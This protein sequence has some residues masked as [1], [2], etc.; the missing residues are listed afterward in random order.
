MTRN[1]DNVL[2]GGLDLTRELVDLWSELPGVMFA[3]KDAAGR[4][5][6]VNQA[7]VRRS[8]A[9]SRAQVIGRTAAELFLPALA[10]RYEAQDAEVM[11][12]GRPLRGELEVIRAEG[13]EP[14]WYLTTKLPLFRQDDAAPPA[15]SSVLAG[16]SGSSGA[17][18]DV[19]AVQGMGPGDRARLASGSGARSSGG[20]GPAAG[21]GRIAAGLVTI[22]T[23]LP[24]LGSSGQIGAAL[25]RVVAAVRAGL[26][27]QPPQLP[28][29]AS[30]AAAAGTSVSA[31]ERNMRKVF[32]LSPRAYV[33]QQRINRAMYLLAETD[34][35]ISEVATATGFYDQ[36]SL[37]RQLVR[38]VGETPGGFRH[39][40]R[41]RGIGQGHAPT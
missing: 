22:S 24:G 9:T 5:V 25:T 40:P 7:F 18:G 17:R 2:L 14:A 20:A 21:P 30:L 15:S 1:E 23:E 10:E 33:L 13:G 26:A 27:A 28:S 32:G 34:Q 8:S 3:I 6:E 4:Y 38:L 41:A 31:L 12:T 39:R 11:A 37:T 36:P 19:L 16:R 35:P 29:V